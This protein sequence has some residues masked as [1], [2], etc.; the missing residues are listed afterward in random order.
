MFCLY[1]F[2][3]DFS[4]FTDWDLLTSFAFDL[5]FFGAAAFVYFL[6]D[7]DFDFLEAFAPFALPAGLEDLA[8]EAETRDFAGDVFLEAVFSFTCSNSVSSFLADCLLARLAAEA[9]T[10]GFFAVDWEGFLYDFLTGEA[11]FLTGDGD[12]L[13][14]DADLLDLGEVLDYDFAGDDFLE[15]DFCFFAVD[16]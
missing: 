11:D 8:G 2:G 7:L 10:A 14:G 15:A 3:A 13:V 9:A 6:T 12:F 1:Y 5:D 16:F 4:D